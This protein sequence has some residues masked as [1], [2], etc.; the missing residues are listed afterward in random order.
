MFPIIFWTI[1]FSISGASVAVLLGDRGLL[2]GN[3]LNF[4]KLLSIVFHWKFI[5]AIFLSFIARYS[6]M[7][8]NSSLLKIP[9]LAGN[10]TTITAFITSVSAIFLI[11][12]NYFFLGE[13][14]NFQQGIG[15]FI[16]MFG[17]W[18]MLK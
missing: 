4:G 5:L 8:I 17:V 16:I 12:A 18:I 7:L 3:L 11:L 2:A 1:I 6:F 14:I 9:E 10:S 13:K 15:A